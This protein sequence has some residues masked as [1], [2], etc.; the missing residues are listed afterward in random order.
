MVLFPLEDEETS[1]ERLTH[2]L[3]LT[4]LVSS[5]QDLNPGESDR[6]VTFLY[7]VPR[8]LLFCALEPWQRAFALGGASV[9]VPEGRLVP[10]WA[11]QQGINA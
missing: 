6:G 4:Q 9:G 2:L 8:H 7:F 1:S 10:L 3:M 11:A 5:Q